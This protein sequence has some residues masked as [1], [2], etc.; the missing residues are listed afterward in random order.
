[1]PVYGRNIGCI[2]EVSRS[3]YKNLYANPVVCPLGEGFAS[4]KALDLGAGEVDFVN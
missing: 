4:M 2:C 3:K 1:M